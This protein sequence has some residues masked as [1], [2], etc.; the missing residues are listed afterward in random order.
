MYEVCDSY[1][2]FF[3]R[4]KVFGLKEREKG[5][6]ELIILITISVWMSYG[7]LSMSKNTHYFSFSYNLYEPFEAPNDFDFSHIGL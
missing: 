4:S 3:F 6:F 5:R 7:T 1:N 2:F